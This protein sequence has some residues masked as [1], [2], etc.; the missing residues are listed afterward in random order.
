MT[1]V[2]ALLIAIAFTHEIEKAQEAK[3]LPLLF[4]A[5][6]G[7]LTAVMPFEQLCECFDAA[8]EDCNL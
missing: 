7:Q 2:E 3:K 8:L 1:R 5:F 6:I 4:G